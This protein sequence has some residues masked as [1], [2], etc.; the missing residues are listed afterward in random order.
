VHQRHQVPENVEQILNDLANLKLDDRPVLGDR[1]NINNV[2]QQA[3]ANA[4][5][6][7]AEVIIV[8]SDDTDPGELG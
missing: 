5:K 2:V 4:K 7:A 6:P 8:I 1:K 3:K